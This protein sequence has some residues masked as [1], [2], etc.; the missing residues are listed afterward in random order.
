MPITFER[1]VFKSGDSYRITIPMEIIRA[2][3]IKEKEKLRIWLDNSHIII[4]KITA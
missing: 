2:L 4:E 3:D 1:A